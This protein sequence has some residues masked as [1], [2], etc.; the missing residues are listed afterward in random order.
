MSDQAYEIAEMQRQL[1]NMVRIGVIDQLNFASKKVKVKSGDVET[2]WLD[3]PA[4]IG[5]N[6]KRWRP[7]R[8]GTQVTIV[9][10]SGDLEQAQIATMLYSDALQS[11]SVDEDIDL[12][13]FDNGS[14]IKHNASN[15][16]M[17][18][19]AAGKLRLTA[20]GNVHLIGTQVHFN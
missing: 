4:E 3:W 5:N 17:E 13:Q 14:F 16:E 1:A 18:I 10:P 8:L 19:H 9:S 15:G 20:D 7:L 12:I 6:Y 11:P 2:G